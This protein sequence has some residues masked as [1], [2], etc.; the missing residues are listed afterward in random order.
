MNFSVISEKEARW[1][2]KKADDKVAAIKLIADLTASNKEQVAEFFGI[3]L[4]KGE[5]GRLRVEPCP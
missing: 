2:F 3:N 5:N 4:V 1:K